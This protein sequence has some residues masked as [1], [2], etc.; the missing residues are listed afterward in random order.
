MNHKLVCRLLKKDGL[1]AEIDIDGQTLTLSSKY[2]PKDC[3]INDQFQLY[4]LSNS[5]DKD[6][7]QSILE[8]IL[9]GK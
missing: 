2:L 4:F 7:A 8:E 9:N 1:K 6:I 5:V 3:A